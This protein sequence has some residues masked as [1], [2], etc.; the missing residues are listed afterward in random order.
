MAGGTRCRERLLQAAAAKPEQ[1]LDAGVVERGEAEFVADEQAVA[2]QRL[3]N[4]ADGDVGQGQAEGFDNVSDG[5]VADL[6]PGGG[7]R[8]ECKE[9]WDLS[10][11]LPG[12]MSQVI[13]DALIH[14]SEASQSNVAAGIEEAVTPNLARALAR[15]SDSSRAVSRLLRL[16]PV[17]LRDDQAAQVPG[18][19]ARRS[20]SGQQAGS[21]RTGHPDRVIA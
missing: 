8:P 7:G 3:D 10:R 15:S 19:A 4:A 11:C 9:P 18:G 16:P 1:Q 21:V 20:V 2:E 5:E 17:G 12:P 14:S 6:V 13:P